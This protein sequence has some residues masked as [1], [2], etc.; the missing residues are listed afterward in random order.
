MITSSGLATRPITLADAFL[1]ARARGLAWDGV[2]VIAGA[3]LTAGAAQVAFTMPW[4]AV[5]YTLQTGAVLLVGTALGVRR[6]VAAMI[7]YVLLG[8]VGL[9]VFAGQASGIEKLF[10]FTG[11]YLIGF[12]GAAGLVGRLAEL[13]WD[14]TAWQTIG[15]MVLGTLLIYLIGVPVLAAGSGLP[16][17]DA[18]YQGAIVFLPWDAAKVVIAAGLLPLTWRLVGDG[19]ATRRQG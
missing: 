7:L 8:V 19:S 2:L 10:G 17:A 14:R 1:G 3:A 15:L 13:A 9:P 11:G 12:I 6:G 5:P 16:L 4:T 18:I